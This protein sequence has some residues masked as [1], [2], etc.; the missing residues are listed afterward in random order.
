ME[1]IT[2]NL[3]GIGVVFSQLFEWVGDLVVVIAAN[4]LLLISTGIFVAGSVIG[5]TKRVI[6]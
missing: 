1:G 6:G 3:D 2:T 5:L 4:P